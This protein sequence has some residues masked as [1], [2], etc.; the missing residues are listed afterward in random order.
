MK[1]AT[2][3]F[4]FVLMTIIT[5]LITS[6]CRAQTNSIASSFVFSKG[7]DVG[8]LPQMEATG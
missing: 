2:A 8:W 6:F 1:K 7:A 3:Q 5:L 4:R